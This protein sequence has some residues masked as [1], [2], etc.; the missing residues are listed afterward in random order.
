M[1]KSISNI[2]VLYRAYSNHYA[3]WSP[4]SREYE[5]GSSPN[6]DQS[7]L[8]P[9][10]GVLDLNAYYKLPLE[11]NGVK[12]ELF[13]NVDVNSWTCCSMPEKFLL[14]IKCAML[15]IY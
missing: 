11:Y 13:V 12:S 8:T 9:S 3:D 10:Y 1:L 5:D 6:R 14:Q 2:Q 15:F 7:W 4:T